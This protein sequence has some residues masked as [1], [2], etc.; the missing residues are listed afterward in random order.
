MKRLFFRIHIIFKAMI[1][2][3]RPSLL[4][5]WLQPF[6][7]LFTNT[8]SLTHWIQK[9]RKKAEFNDYFTWKIDNNKRFNLYN[10]I[11]LQFKLEL[12]IINYFEFGVSTGVSFKYWTTHLTNSK[13]RYFGF[14]TFEGLP[15]KWG[16]FYE[17]G[18]MKSNVPN[19]NDDRATFIKGLF[20]DTLPDFLVNNTID[21]SIKK[22]IHLDADLFTST[23]FVLGSIAPILNKGDILIFDEFNVPN[24]EFLAFKFFTESYLVKTKL[25]CAVNNF[26]QVAFL[27]V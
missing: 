1:L 2:F 4:L 22:I 21:K 15:E 26:H 12:S 3:L 7:F 14:D 23:L 24:H 19:L 6:T 13:N 17:K 10:N 9:H 25:I 5:G 11:I 18:D 27:I 16:L 8:L 20:Q